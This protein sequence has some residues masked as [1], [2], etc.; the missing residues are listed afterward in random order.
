MLGEFLYYTILAVQQLWL[1]T[2]G[3][4]AE[5]PTLLDACKTMLG[6]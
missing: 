5:Y 4:Y 1:H 3:I 6:M 2:Q